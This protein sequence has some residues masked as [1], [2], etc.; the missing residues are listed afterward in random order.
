MISGVDQ[1]AIECKAGAR[2][3]RRSE[4]L[5]NDLA[6]QHRPHSGGAD[7]L[8]KHWAYPLDS[9]TGFAQPAQPIRTP[10]V[11][12]CALHQTGVEKSIAVLAERWPPALQPC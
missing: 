5:L 7:E 12:P 11:P 3:R 4:P 10:T 6:C 8:R 2:G 9:K 1:P